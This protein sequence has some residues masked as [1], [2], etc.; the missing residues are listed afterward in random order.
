MRI[1]A[2]MPYDARRRQR[3]RLVCFGLLLTVM[4]VSAAQLAGYWRDAASARRASEELR[5]LY[6]A[7]AAAT[8]TQ[9]P[10]APP[11]MTDAPSAPLPVQ[12]EADSNSQVQQ[13]KLEGGSIKVQ[14]TPYNILEI[15]TPDPL[16]RT[17]SSSQEK[18]CPLQ[19]S[20]SPWMRIAIH[21]PLTM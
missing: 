21:W 1:F 14:T 10:A 7:E 19:P 9:Q 5:A 16:T 15:L 6:Y 17:S 8:A 11:A 18:T 2:Y 20:G 13:V 4:L 12:E 3:L